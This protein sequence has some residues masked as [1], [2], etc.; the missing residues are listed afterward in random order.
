MFHFVLGYSLD[1]KKK[2]LLLFAIMGFVTPGTEAFASA[3][4]TLDR[5]HHTIT[6]SAHLY[7]FGPGAHA[8]DQIQGAVD[9]MNLYWNGGSHLDHSFTPLIVE[10]DRVKYSFKVVVTGS[11]TIHS[12]PSFFS[13]QSGTEFHLPFRRK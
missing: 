2:A 9:E 5:S 1:M 8:T 11:S 3:K 7:F 12:G 13:I 6:V 4:V 10:V